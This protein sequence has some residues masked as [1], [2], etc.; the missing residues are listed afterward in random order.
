MKELLNSTSQSIYIHIPFCKRKC[1]YCAFISFTNIENYEEKYINA[2]CKELE[3]YKTS[4]KIETIYLGGGT[5]NILSIKSLEKIFSTINN[6]YKLSSNVEI[7]MEINPALSNSSYLKELKNLGINRLSVGVQSFD[8]K[9][10]K[11]LNRIHTSKETI[12]TLEI[13]K[14]A[15]F[16]NYSIDL[17]YGIF[18]QKLSDIKKELKIIKSLDLKHVSTYG[19]KIEENT[20]FEKFDKTNLPQEEECAD[21]Y[22][23]ISEELEKQGFIHYEISNYAKQGFE[24][25]HN[26]VY[27]KNKEYFGFGSSAHGYLNKIRYKNSSNLEKYIENPLQKEITNINKTQDIY[28]ETVFLGL[29]LK[30]GID[31][32]EI[33]NKFGIDLKAKKKQIIQNLIANDYASME[34]ENLSLTT[35]GFLIS[36]YI[37]GELL[38]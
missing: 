12:K 5:P 34:N 27:W 14:K 32:N 16:T 3:E 37:I 18:T 11:I 25:K 23:L 36:N 33:K 15:G 4:N 26:L 22:T 35:K 8:D 20:P 38:D 29:R 17:M 30:Q 2:L 19:L 7:T 13:I 1:N 21:M 31:L 9:I 10:L 6:N 28:E 24:S